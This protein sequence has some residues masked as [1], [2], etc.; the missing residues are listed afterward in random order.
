M[1]NP[2]ADQGRTDIGRAG[3][4]LGRP[5]QAFYRP[6]LRSAVFI[7][8]WNQ[9]ATQF[10]TDPTSLTAYGRWESRAGEGFANSGAV[11]PTFSVLADQFSFYSGVDFRLPPAEIAST[12]GEVMRFVDNLE[13]QV[14]G[15]DP[16]LVP[17][18]TIDLEAPLGTVPDTRAAYLCPRC[19]KL[20]ILRRFVPPKSGVVHFQTLHCGIDI[21]PPMRDAWSEVLRLYRASTGG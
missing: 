20:E 15:V 10:L 2:V 12:V 1:F 14:T 9:R 19:G 17:F 6:P 11:L 13:Y 21:F 7:E 5:I 16:R 3:V 8:S 18:P 4:F